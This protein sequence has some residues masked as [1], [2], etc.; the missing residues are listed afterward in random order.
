MVL[1]LCE[2]C[3]Y[4]LDTS[5]PLPV[6][7]CLKGTG[8]AHSNTFANRHY[9]LRS[10]LVWPGRFVR[11][12]EAHDAPFRC[13]ECDKHTPKGVEEKKIDTDREA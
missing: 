11:D 10:D 8:S 6:Q 12:G 1:G 2:T 3:C 13:V 9:I 5:V 4:H 7:L